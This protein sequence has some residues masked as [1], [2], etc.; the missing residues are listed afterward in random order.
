MARV[1]GAAM[2]DHSKEIKLRQRILRG[3]Q[4]KGS[5]GERR[6]K[7]YPSANPADLE[8]SLLKAFKVD[9]EDEGR[10]FDEKLL[11]C[12]VVDCLLFLLFTCGRS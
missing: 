5:K 6:A 1:K 2:Y 11:C 3:S 4:G 12:I 10:F 9:G 8:A 7:L